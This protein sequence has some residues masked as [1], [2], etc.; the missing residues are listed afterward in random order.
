[1][2]DLAFGEEAVAGAEAGVEFGGLAAEFGEGFEVDGELEGRADAD[3][4]PAETGADRGAR[5]IVGVAAD[6]ERGDV[7]GLG[8]GVAVDVDVVDAG[9]RR[10]REALLE[11]VVG[12]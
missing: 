12:A 5:R 1:M 6:V 7:A 3:G 8:E 11:G 10:E 9:V 2:A 4:A